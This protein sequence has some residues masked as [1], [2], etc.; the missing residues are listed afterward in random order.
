MQAI[1]IKFYFYKYISSGDFKYNFN[2]ACRKCK[3]IVS[4][5]INEEAQ[6]KPCKRETE[7]K[8]QR[9]ERFCS[10]NVVICPKV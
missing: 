1:S 2:L 8:N 5:R 6:I 7:N 3:A 9:P 4:P 10:S